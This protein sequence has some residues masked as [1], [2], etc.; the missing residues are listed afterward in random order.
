VPRTRRTGWRDGG[1]GGGGQR[2]GSVGWV[3]YDSDMLE[4]REGRGE[5]GAWP[6]R[7]PT[8]LS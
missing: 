5:A 8:L 1:W 2:E 7:A 3:H 6:R 4:E